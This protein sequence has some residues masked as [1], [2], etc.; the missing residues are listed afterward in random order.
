MSGGL[1]EAPL[2]VYIAE[3]VEPKYRGMLTASG[4]ATVYGGVCLSFIIG[5]M[6]H[7]KQVAA[8][9][10]IIPF[11]A[12]IAVFFVPETPYWLVAQNRV[13][14]A[15]KSLQWLRGWVPHRIVETEFKDIISSVEDLRAHKKAL[16]NIRQDSCVSQ[17]IVQST[18][19]KLKPF[20][21]RNFIAPF[22]LVFVS[23]VF[24]HFSGLTP[25]QTYSIQILQSYHVPINEYH[26]TIGLGASQLIGCLIG[27][28]FVRAS[29][30]RRLVFASFIGCGI[31]FCAVA[32]HGYTSNGSN[33][34]DLVPNATS[35]NE[36]VDNLEK[37]VLNTII[38][39][40]NRYRI[41]R[42][43]GNFLNQI[44]KRVP[45]FN[46][47]AFNVN[48]CTHVDPEILT[49][50]HR[51]LQELRH[52]S[53]LSNDTHPKKLPGFI[54]NGMNATVNDSKPTNST[55]RDEVHVQK[56]FE[57]LNIT[58]NIIITFVP[59]VLPTNDDSNLTVA[60]VKEIETN[61]WNVFV[62]NVT[63]M[64]AHLVVKVNEL[65]ITLANVAGKI[66]LGSLAETD[67]NYRW[68]PLILLLGGSMFA[69]C[70][71]K[72]FPWMLIGEVEHLFIHFF[73]SHTFN[74][75]EFYIF[76]GKRNAEHFISQF[77]S[78]FIKWKFGVQQPVCR[79]QLAI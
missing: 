63:V 3:T 10:A 24:S 17:K 54:G 36:P 78:R 60:R 18:S 32:T 40:R 38:S 67:T 42:D 44:D 11:C 58:K 57:L 12:I 16:P 19:N 33:Q 62:S 71:S 79:V 75:I 22:A 35:L 59:Y 50:T 45:M 23:F 72:L 29:G 61:M 68:I 30:K 26:A 2:L 51:L 13:D 74:R 49:E 31:C 15:H 8:L 66:R 5:S 21:K 7:W 27:V 55:V 39:L 1:L 73:F 20:T 56:L 14:D 46:E 76:F 52:F 69:H 48:N 64:E 53:S 77:F 70:G 43:T 65:S 34:F 6:M 41:E 9:S 28:A 4:T 25:L 37:T 47:V